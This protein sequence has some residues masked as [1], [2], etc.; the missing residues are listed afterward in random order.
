[1]IKIKYKYNLNV[2]NGINIPTRIYVEENY[3]F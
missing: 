3:S 2:L 1:M